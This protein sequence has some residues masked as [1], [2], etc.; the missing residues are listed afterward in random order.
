MPA[1]LYVAV[2]GVV[3]AICGCAGHYHNVRPDLALLFSDN[4][5]HQTREICRRC[6]DVNSSF[7]GVVKLGSPRSFNVSDLIAFAKSITLWW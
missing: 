3:V 7:G 6:G 5:D 4:L 1:R 2:Q